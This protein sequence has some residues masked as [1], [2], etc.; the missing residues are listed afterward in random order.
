MRKMDHHTL[1][2]SPGRTLS[3]WDTEYITRGNRIDSI[4]ATRCQAL[5]RSRSRSNSVAWRSPVTN[6]DRPALRNGTNGLSV[7]LQ[8]VLARRQARW[9]TQ[10]TGHRTTSA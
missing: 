1:V 7:R 4:A 5:R 6:D 10:S 3:D 2:G 9:L 8:N